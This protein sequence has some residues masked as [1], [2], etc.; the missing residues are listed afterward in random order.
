[1]KLFLGL[2]SGL[3]L[4]LSFPP[5]PTGVAV[6]IAFVPFFLLLSTLENY[7]STF[8]YTYFTIFIFNLIT[9][10][11]AGGFVHLKDWYMMVAGLLLIIGHPLF[12]IVP[13]FVWLF[14]RKQFGF[15]ISIY[16]FPFI[17]VGFE[18]LHGI[19]D[20][21]F[22][23]LT[24]GNTQT[25]DLSVVQMASITGAY[26][27][28]FWILWINVLIFLLFVKLFL[29]EWNISEKRSMLLIATILIM[30]FIPKI[31]GIILLDGKPSIENNNVSISVIQPNIDTF[32]KWTGDPTVPF[33]ILQDQTKDIRSIHPDLV[34]WPETAIPFYI[35]QPQNIYYLNQLK[36]TVDYLD[37][38]LLAGIPDIAYYSPTDHFPQSSKISKSGERY[39]SFNSSILLSPH[40]S[41]IQKYSKIVLV[42]FA[43]RVPFSEELSFLDIMEWN[44]GLGGWGHGRDTT[45]FEINL[46]NGRIVKFSNL[47]CYESV[48][49]TF[50]RTFVKNGAEFLTVITNDSWWGNTSGAYQH[51]QIAIMRAVENRRW[52][53]QCANGGISCF[54]DAYGTIVQQSDLYTKTILSQNV[55]ASK[56]I[57]FYTEYGDWLAEMCVMLSLFFVMAAIS[58]K[59]YKTLRSRDY[60]GIH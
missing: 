11:W 10:Y 14:I 2:L 33:E 20:L 23:W 1:M 7:G 22:P 24:I 21:G 50:V 25:Y 39:D 36:R 9:T 16:T 12:F 59:F 52:V 15:K 13:V 5:V 51:K 56:E 8:R 3:L 27:I 32:E 54:I 28:S 49:P 53:V 57:T 43:E 19:G 48:F 29:K 46:R 58:G 18:Y 55:K 38:H 35:L 6:L 47:I 30:Y 60:H 44:F 26:G 4:G 37:I 17:W 41:N 42:P 34:L 40:E 31:Y 45:V